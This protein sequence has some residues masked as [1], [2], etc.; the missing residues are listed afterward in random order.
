[1]SV[2]YAH[3][4][5]KENL[6]VLCSLLNDWNYF[7]NKYCNLPFL[8]ICHS[9]LTLLI[10]LASFWNQKAKTG[11]QMRLRNKKLTNYHIKGL[12]KT[13]T[14][15]NFSHFFFSHECAKSRGS[16]GYR[17]SFSW[18]ILMGQTRG[19]FSWVILVGHSRGSN[20]WVILV[21]HSRRSNLWVKLVVYS[22]GSNSRFI[23]VGQT[24]GP[25]LWVKFVGQTCGSFSWIKLV[26]QTRGSFS[27]VK[28]VGQTRGSFRGSNSWV[29][30][31][32]HSL[33]SNS[34]VILVD[35]EFVGNL[36]LHRII[37]RYIKQKIY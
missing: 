30:L 15:R 7:S 29:K 36:R 8:A 11:L 9:L 23:L 10:F 28:L 22:R 12:Y 35:Q 31:M 5:S 2:I 18:V 34:W 20:S 25:F 4:V 3:F 13:K 27:W 14:K 6:F 24:R 19:W 16:G 33:G 1:M 21:G 17:G 32:G 37:S 26:D